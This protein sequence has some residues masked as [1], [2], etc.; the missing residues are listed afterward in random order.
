VSHFLENFNI[1]AAPSGV[2]VRSV[3]RGE[4]SPEVE[5][6]VVLASMFKNASQGPE[7]F[8]LIFLGKDDWTIMGRN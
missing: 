3:E 6:A 4:K 5:N 7:H 2:R 8:F 1:L